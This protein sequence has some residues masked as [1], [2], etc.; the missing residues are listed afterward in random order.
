MI[1]KELFLTR[2]DGVNLYR[3]YSDQQFKIIQQDTGIEYY[4]AVDPEY[5]NHTYIESDNKI[6][7]V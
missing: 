3:T 4:E 1:Q 6:E 7:E 5:I 2:Q